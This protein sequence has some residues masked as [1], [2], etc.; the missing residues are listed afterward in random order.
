VQSI[1]P[2]TELGFDWGELLWLILSQQEVMAQ[3]PRSMQA[4]CKFVKLS[5]LCRQYKVSNQAGPKSCDLFATETRRD[6]TLALVKTLNSSN[7]QEHA[8]MVQIM[9]VSAHLA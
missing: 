9:V 3:A 4:Y 7:M 8:L 6:L 1:P 5:A 2:G